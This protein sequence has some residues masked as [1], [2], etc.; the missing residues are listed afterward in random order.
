MAGAWL[1]AASYHLGPGHFYQPAYSA[2]VQS[3]DLR[4][5]TLLDLGCGPG[6]FTV[7]AARYSPELMCVGLDRDPTM[8]RMAQRAARGIPNC[9][10]L[11]EEASST[12]LGTGEVDTV[13]SVQSMH[14]WRD[15]EAILE[16]LR[17]ILRPGARAHLLAADPEG[18]IPPGWIRRRAGWPRDNNLRARWRRYSLDAAGFRSVC[19]SAARLFDGR[20]EVG[21]LG[22]YRHLELTR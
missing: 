5:G 1:T 12:S 15:T 2:L 11:L 21:A 3:L 13:V 4:A 18:Q 8:W 7:A 6:G 19:H 14:H 20:I 9:R 22:F 16:E 10:F 17:R